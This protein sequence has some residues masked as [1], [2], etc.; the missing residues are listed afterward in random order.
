MAPA[1]MATPAF[2][3]AFFFQQVHLAEAV[4]V[5]HLGLVAL[6]PIYS[7]ISV[8]AMLGTGWLVDRFGTT[9][10]MRIFLL[11][12]ALSF[13][14]LSQASSLTGLAL[15]IGLL[16]VTVGANNTLPAAFWADSFGTRHLGAIKAMAMALMVV[17]SA[18]GPLLTGVLIDAGVPFPGQMP[19]ISAFILG[20]AGLLTLSLAQLHRTSARAL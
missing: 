20:S 5:A 12:L 3:T 13:V 15:G 9:V 11:P 6:F 10:L 16:A 17:G 7:V 19:G 8:L 4:G 14:I 2:V 1:L 18:L